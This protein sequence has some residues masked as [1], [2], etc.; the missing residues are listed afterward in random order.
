[1]LRVKTFLVRK[2]DSDEYFFGRNYDL[3]HQK[4]NIDKGWENSTGLCLVIRSTNPKAKYKSLGV[5]DGYWFD[6]KHGHFFEGT[7]DDGK[8]DITP[9]ALAPLLLMDGINEAGVAASIMHIATKNEWNEIPYI[10]VNQLTEEEKKNI[11]IL[12]EAN[13]KPKRNDLTVKD[14]NIA[15]NIVDKKAWKV[16]KKF[17]V[18]Q[19]EPGKEEIY[20]PVLLRK[21]I[22]YAS[23]VDEAIAIAKS[24]NVVSP[25]PTDDYHIFVAD[26]FGRSILL[27]WVNNVLQVVETKHGT[28]YLM[29]R[30]IE[31][32]YGYDRDDLLTK[33]LEKYPDGMSEEEASELLSSVVQDVRIKRFSSISQWS[34]L[35]NLNRGEMKIRV[36]SDF[37]KIYNYK[38]Q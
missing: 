25:L 16:N 17:A 7:L 5:V 19:T 22:D 32:G 3:V 14:G 24:Y 21:I 35:Y 34:V 11:K 31:N 10:D 18:H 27:E 2:K 28:N 33:G 26:K 37:S 38:I 15:I 23:N 12:N 36:F 4:F 9:F 8:T 1:M 13:A 29:F 30:L 6:Y 20:H